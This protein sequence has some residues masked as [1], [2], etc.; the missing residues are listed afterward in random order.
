MRPAPESLIFT[1]DGKCFFR[2]Q[3]A[4]DHCTK[5]NLNADEIIDWMKVKDRPFKLIFEPKVVRVIVTG[6]P[7]LTDYEF[8]KTRLN[9]ILKNVDKPIE[10]VSGGTE[11]AD[12]LGERFAKERA[13]G[14]R[15]FK[16]NWKWHGNNAGVKR[17]VEMMEHA[18]HCVIFDSG[19]VES[20]HTKELAEKYNLVSR[21][22][23][24]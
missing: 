24:C 7:R 13:F 9:H 16:P 20:K 18:T 11:G 15:R 1:P 5:Y 3:E 8:L 10:I 23:A 21:I 17:R 14:L 12:E 22:I 19:D 2:Q 4:A 6:S